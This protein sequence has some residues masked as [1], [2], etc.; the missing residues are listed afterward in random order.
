MDDQRAS[1]RTSWAPDLIKV[2]HAKL[3]SMDREGGLS[4]AISVCHGW[5]VP[6]ASF[7]LRLLLAGFASLSSH[8]SAAK[9]RGMTD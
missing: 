2:C 3:S 7:V 1:R 4:W 6:L 8:D 9:S 5:G